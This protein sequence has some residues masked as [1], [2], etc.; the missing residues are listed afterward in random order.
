MSG[1]AADFGDDQT[2]ADAE[3]PH[4]LADD[5]SQRRVDC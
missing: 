4:V 5:R 3:D 2:E 1:L